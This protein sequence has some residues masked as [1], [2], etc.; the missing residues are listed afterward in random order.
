MD[1]NVLHVVNI[2]FVIPYFLGKQFLY[3]KEKGYEEYVICSPSK[4]LEELS[5]IYNFNFR[6]VEILRKISILKDFR[7]VFQTANY[8]KKKQIDIV[9]GHTPK[10]ALVAMLAACLMKVP[11]RIY[12]RHGL[13]YETSKGF[14]RK[15]L[16]SMD[17][18]AA[19]LA[20]KVICVSPSV[21]KRS[22]EDKLNAESKQC[23]LSRG[24]CNGI[25][26]E[27]F[28]REK[29]NVDFLTELKKDLGLKQSDFVIGFTGRLVRDKG[30]IELVQAFQKLQVR[31]S[32]LILLLVGMLEERDALPD[33]IVDCIIYNDN[34]INTGYVKNSEIE[35]YYALMDIFVL[36]SYREGFPTSVLEASAMKIPIITT[37][38]TG[39][40]DSI[41]ENET[42]IF[43][44]HNS[45]DLMEKIDTMYRD[46]DQ[47]AC[48]GI[49]G[50]NFVIDN[51]EQH[52]IWRDIE[53]L[54]Q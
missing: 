15:L 26:I 11:T 30:I 50:R 21:Y 45:N 39:C 1:K 46:Q 36:P 43:V 2:S 52:I 5:Q 42:G 18:L 12:I 48:L 47:R 51:F 31:Y 7:A 23:I 28:C 25:D 24:T 38:V 8:I 54:Y 27:R 32:N 34:I 53:K 49:N 13:V 35:Y 19:L 37:K 14:K 41:I 20:T 33:D 16:V 4:E 6:E 3:F 40:V 9:V 10:G 17:R 29:I 44:E 22:L